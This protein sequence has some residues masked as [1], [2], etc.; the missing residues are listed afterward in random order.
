[1]PDYLAGRLDTAGIDTTIATMIAPRR[2]SGGKYWTTMTAIQWLNDLPLWQSAFLLVG[3][4]IFVSYIGTVA[5]RA[6]FGEQQLEL[7]NILGGFKYLAMSQV[8][9]AFLGFLLLGAYQRYDT[10]RT[11]IVTEA[12]ALTTLDRLAD[13][14]PEGARD[15]FRV[16]LKDYARE[17]IDVEWPRMGQRKADL[18][19]A[20]SLD[21]LYYVFSAIEATSKN[22]HVFREL[23]TTNTKQ[24]ELIKYARELVDGIRDVRGMRMLRSLGSVQFLLW[25]AVITGT[26]VAMMFPWLFGTANPAAAFA[27]SILSIGLMTSMVLV[28][29][30]LSY[31]FGGTEGLQPTP[32]LAFLSETSARR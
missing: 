15:Q 5:A 25:V 11:N 19:T 7:N 14:F 6:Y 23:Q 4:T 1:V 24:I 12:N 8:Y 21:T 17:V 9:G 16:A 2:W 20:A 22:L 10:V 27:M 30:K 18:G 29:L 26:A 31:P 3:G 32:Y 28:I 13:A